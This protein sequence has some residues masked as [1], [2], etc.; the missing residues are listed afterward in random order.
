[1]P[2]KLEKSI[3]NF[4]GYDIAKHGKQLRPESHLRFLL[5]LLG[6]DLVI[7]VGAN[8]GQYGEMLRDLGFEGWILSFEPLPDAFA[9]LERRLARDDRWLGL[10]LALGDAEATA[11]LNVSRNSVFSSLHAPNARGRDQFSPRI[12]VVDTIEVAVRRLDDVLPELL[13]RMR[14]GAGGTTASGRPDLSPYRCL[15]KMD[16]QGHDAAV[17]DGGREA[18]AQSLALHSELSVAGIYED[19]PDYLEMLGRYRALGFELT[20]IYPA[21]RDR[22]TG[23]VVELDCI[24]ARAGA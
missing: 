8:N 17:L 23:H 5:P 19:L 24:M 18:A 14:P 16:T 7:D 9:E 20:G 3:A 22:H 15:L 6:I 4:L 2:K 11:E 13:E 1:M 10:P 21:E 12:D